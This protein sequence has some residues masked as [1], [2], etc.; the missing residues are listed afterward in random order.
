VAGPH[1]FEDLPLQVWT[2]RPD[3]SLDYVNAFT[4]RYFGL[5]SHK[6]LDDG[7]KDVCHS[8]DLISAAQRW[9]HC[10]ATGEDYELQFRLLHGGD[11]VYRWHLARAVA[12]RDEDG[13][14]VGWIGTNTD[15]DRMVREREL[16]QAAATRFPR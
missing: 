16:A 3:G 12:M 6:I 5:S 9:A 10:L 8:L 1:S 4:A 13:A 15:I 7:W 14:I 11:R 2:A